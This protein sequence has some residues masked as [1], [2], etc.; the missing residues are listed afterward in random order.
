MNFEDFLIT[1]NSKE[2]VVSRTYMAAPGPGHSFRIKAF[3]RT[4]IYCMV[5]NIFYY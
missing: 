1:E 2:A 4:F 3:Q 5:S